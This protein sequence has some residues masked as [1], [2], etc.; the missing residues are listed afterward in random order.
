LL[1][2]AE[3][4]RAVMKKEMKRSKPSVSCLLS[5]PKRKKPIGGTKIANTHGKQLLEAVKR[6]EAQIVIRE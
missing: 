1:D 2:D 3:P 5:L 6:G 4:Y